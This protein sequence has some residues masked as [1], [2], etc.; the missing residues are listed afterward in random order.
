MRLAGRNAGPLR[1]VLTCALGPA[2]MADAVFAQVCNLEVYKS[3]SGRVGAVV[4]GPFAQDE[5][6]IVCFGVSEPGYVS[7]WDKFPLSGSAERI[8]PNAHDR[9]AQSQRAVKLPRGDRHCFGTGIEGYY[10]FMDPAEGYGVGVMTLMYRKE[11]AAHPAPAD[12][13]SVDVFD[14]GYDSYGVAAPR[15]T[16]AGRASGASGKSGDCVNELKFFYKVAP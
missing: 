12:F 3:K 8:V 2:L 10:L 6:Y 4:D 16:A 13:S 15:G 11:D 9:D 1:T 7:L 14:E 5:E